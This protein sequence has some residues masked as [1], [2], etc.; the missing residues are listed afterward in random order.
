MAPNRTGSWDLV[1][2]RPPRTVGGMRFSRQCYTRQPQ[3]NK[4][5][6]FFLAHGFGIWLVKDTLSEPQG[7]V[8]ATRTLGLVTLDGLISTPAGEQREIAPVAATAYT[9]K[10]F[11]RVELPHAILARIP[12]ASPVRLCVGCHYSGRSRNAAIR[13]I[14]TVEAVAEVAQP[15]HQLGTYIAGRTGQHWCCQNRYL[16]L[17]T[18]QPEDISLVPLGDIALTFTYLGFFTRAQRVIPFLLKSLDSKL[19]SLRKPSQENLE[20]NV[21]D[22]AR[23]ERG[24]L[25]LSSKRDSVTFAA[26]IIYMLVG[27]YD[28]ALKLAQEAW[29][30]LSSRY[31]PTNIK[32]LDC[33]RHGQ[34][35]FRHHRISDIKDPSPSFRGSSRTS[36]LTA[37]YFARLDEN[38]EIDLICYML[39]AIVSWRQKTLGSSHNLTLKSQYQLA[40]A[41]SQSARPKDRKEARSLFLAVFVQR[42][43][44]LG[45]THPDAL[46][47][48]REFIITCAS[49]EQ[50][51]NPD[52]MVILADPATSI[53]SSSNRHGSDEH[54]TITND[55]TEE[56][57]E[58]T[59]EEW[60]EMELCSR[61]IIRDQRT[62]PGPAHPDTIKSL[63]W[64]FTLQC[65]LCKIS[66]ASKTMKTLLERLR[67]NRV[68]DQR[69][70]SSLLTEERIA[71]I[72]LDQKQSADALDILTN[73]AQRC[74]LQEEKEIVESFSQK[75]VNATEF[76]KLTKSA[77]FQNLRG[78]CK[79]QIE[80]LQQDP[81]ELVRHAFELYKSFS[82]EIGTNADARVYLINS[83]RLA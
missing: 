27:N 71:K 11:G 20:G 44:K 43:Y 58:M 30:D 61:G 49:L 39:E 41:K 59:Q 40:L 22:W 28:Q 37:I 47:A 7:T 35:P 26:T 67:H 51:E 42:C 52:K 77:E 34:N 19:G 38:T 62:K 36:K 57:R 81:E 33:S 82:D 8:I 24:K 50:W 64:L 18:D 69:L 68:Q 16:P 6:F 4:T 80:T 25:E 3:A 79:E 78:R 15:D 70:M 29:R 45:S 73:I 53:T 32:A 9:S 63:L 74:K 12:V 83:F 46:T 31:S 2:S 17:P 66:A 76:Q 75:P 21:T 13:E 72:Y 60:E 5:M 23:G 1:A 14:K 54:T 48:K 10:L 56:D 55:R 65:G